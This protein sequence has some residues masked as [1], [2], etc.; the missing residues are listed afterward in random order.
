MTFLAPFHPKQKQAEDKL[1]SQF[2]FTLIELLVVIAIIAILAGMLLP[3]LSKS[4]TK[5]QG[6]MCMSNTK[7]ITFAWLLYAEDNREKVLNSREWMGGD[8]YDANPNPDWTNINILQASK[9]SPF[10]GRNY[11]VYKCPG[12]PRRL[13]KKFPVVRSV[14][15]NCYQGVGW[16]DGFFVFSK[17]S[18][19]IRPNPSGI[20]VI[21]DESK[22]TINDAFF[23]VPMDTYD[24]RNVSGEAFV[25][26]PGTFHNRAGSLSFA[27]GHSE[28][29]RWQDQRTVKAL[30]FEASPK[31]RD[32]EWIQEKS[33]AKIGN[34][35]R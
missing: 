14:S 28:I 27:D 6:I 32:I 9:L 10:L 22:N 19:M 12:D 1:S 24:P 25:D 8:I 13:N 21:L 34:P 4:K 18:D 23:A 20:W 33:T 15:M 3:A 35:T 26:V 5:A 17:L 29:H 7:Q 30:L 11:Q 31:N 16:T 2:A